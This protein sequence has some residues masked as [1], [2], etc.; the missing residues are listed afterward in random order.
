VQATAIRQVA[1]LHPF[2]KSG[3]IYSHTFTEWPGMYSQVRT[4]FR[5]R[6]ESNA[7]LRGYKYLLTD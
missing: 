3:K 4:K 6:F 7:E 2:L 5:T 1:C